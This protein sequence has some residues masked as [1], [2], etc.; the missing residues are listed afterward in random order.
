[1]RVCI[2][3]NAVTAEDSPDAT[4]VLAQVAAVETALVDLGHKTDRLACDLDLRAARQQLAELQPDIV[5]NLV[6]S[7][8]GLGS[9]IHLLPAL[10]DGLAIPY[11]GNRTAAMTLTSDKIAAKQL[12]GRHGLPTP[13]WVGPWP[14]KGNEASTASFPDRQ[15]IIKSLWEDASIGLDEGA[16][17]TAGNHQILLEAM[18]SRAPLL[19]GR[20]FAEEFIE[21]REFNIALLAGNDGPLVLPPAE[22]VFEGFTQDMPRIVG[23]QAKW[24]E[25]SYEYNHTLRSF[26][27]PA[28]DQALLATLGEQAGRCWQIFG[29][30]GYARV[31]F[32]ID[33]QGNPWIL[34]INANPCLSPDA[35]YAA[36]L[37]RAGISFA[38]AIQRIMG[39]ALVV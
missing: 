25:S 28:T 12:L 34:E 21:G 19:G 9:L 24:N 17:I 23:Y 8:D 3:Y 2:A 18:A 38:S 39:E 13:S 20:C 1:M 10:L 11:T 30:A 29:L 14:R 35:G 4:D 6:E 26:D 36:A 27:F 31:D 5:F 37:D 32:R 16:I 15:W 7:L 22:I 33:R